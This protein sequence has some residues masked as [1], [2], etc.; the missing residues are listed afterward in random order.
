MVSTEVLTFGQ[1][2]RILIE[3]LVFFIL[4]FAYLKLIHP[5]DPFF[6]NLIVTTG[7][8]ALWAFTVTIMNNIS[9]SLTVPKTREANV[10]ISAE[11]PDMDTLFPDDDES[12]E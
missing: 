2:I 11:D 12:S 5:E 4:Y 1:G 9:L 10:S 3:I 6:T 7:L 8:Y